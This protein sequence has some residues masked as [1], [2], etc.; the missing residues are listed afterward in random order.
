MGYAGTA[1][2]MRL[3]GHLMPARMNVARAASAPLPTLR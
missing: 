3:D 2:T 1:V